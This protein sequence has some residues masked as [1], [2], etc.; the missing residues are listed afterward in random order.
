MN[1]IQRY[2]QDLS[3][4]KH[5]KFAVEHT[6]RLLFA[7][8][9]LGGLGNL[10]GGLIYDYGERIDRPEMPWPPDRTDRGPR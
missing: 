10:T 2:R 3:L 5:T 6:A 4:P 7:I 1:R 9:I 8:I